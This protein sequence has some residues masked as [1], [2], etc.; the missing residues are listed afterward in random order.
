VNHNVY[1]NSICKLK[2]INTN[3]IAVLTFSAAGNALRIELG[4]A[5]VFSLPG[6]I[7]YTTFSCVT[8]HRPYFEIIQSIVTL[9]NLPLLTN[10]CTFTFN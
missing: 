1:M 8:H 9:V 4:R 10:C 2:F 5:N 6:F 7:L 3:V